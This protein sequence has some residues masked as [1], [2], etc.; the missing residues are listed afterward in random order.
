MKRSRELLGAGLAL[1]TILALGACASRSKEAEP[2]SPSS[3]SA[4]YGVLLKGNRQVSFLNNG[5]AIIS[6]PAQEGS[7]N[8][9]SIT[10]ERCDNT[11]LLTDSDP[12]NHNDTEDMYKRKSVTRSPNDPKCADSRL[13]AEDYT[14]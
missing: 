11:T 1:T 5:D 8:Q 13:M 9:A 14:K 12:H 3:L 2:S 6:T 4:S 7:D 10:L